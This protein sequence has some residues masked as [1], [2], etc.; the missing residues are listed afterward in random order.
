MLEGEHAGGR[1][2]ESGTYLGCF[3]L[4]ALHSASEIGEPLTDTVEEKLFLTTCFV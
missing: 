2:S 4:N 1:E 3:F